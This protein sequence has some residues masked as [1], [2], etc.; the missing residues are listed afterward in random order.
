MLAEQ[1]S[2]FGTQAFRSKAELCL[3]QKKKKTKNCKYNR[4]ESNEGKSLTRTDFSE[5]ISA[6]DFEMISLIG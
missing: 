6:D 4:I 1:L 5:Q 2:W 3:K